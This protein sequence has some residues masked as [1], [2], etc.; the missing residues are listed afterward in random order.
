VSDDNVF[1]WDMDGSLAD[2][3]GG[4]LKY[5]AKIRGPHDPVLHLESIWDTEKREPWFKERIRLIK[6]LPGFWKN[7]DPIL[8]GFA[9]YKMAREMG[10]QNEVLTKGPK[11]HSTAW[12][13]KVEWCAHY[14]GE[15]LDVHVVSN[16][17]RVYGKVLYDDFPDYVE[18]WL[19]HRPRGLVIM[20]VKKSA[21]LTHPV[22]SHPNVIKWDGRDE[23]FSYIG[24]MLK[25]VLTRKP[26][27][28]LDLKEDTPH[29]EKAHDGRSGDDHAQA[30][31]RPDP[32]PVQEG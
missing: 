17:S 23:T 4:L 27:E 32:A 13:E 18:G 14:F 5:L 20:P 21:T 9:V 28:P 30:D 3:E 24:R 19:A 16:K 12:A 25:R 22:Y 31:Q 11:K 8:K 29:E 2:Y 10:F 1:L 7:L 26:N 15:D 6:S